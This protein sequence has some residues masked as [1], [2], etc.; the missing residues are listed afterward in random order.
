MCRQAPFENTSVGLPQTHDP[1]APHTRP[2]A[3]QLGVQHR[4]LPFRSGEQ[5]LDAHWPPAVQGCA[6]GSKPLQTPVAVLQPLP[7]WLVT[8]EPSSQREAIVPWH[9]EP[10]PSHWTHREP[11]AAQKL[12]A[13]HACAQHTLPPLSLLTHAFDAHPSF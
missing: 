6:L 13:A 11:S 3:A 7:H 2:E 4:W 8:S 5:V 10:A 12:P 1:S 9:V